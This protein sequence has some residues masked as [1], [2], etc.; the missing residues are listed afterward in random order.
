MTA[1]LAAPYPPDDEKP[2]SLPAMLPLLMMLPEPWRR[3]WGAACFMPSMT[4]RNRVAIAASKRATSRPSMPPVCA[5]PPALLNRQS[6]RPNFSTACAISPRISSSTV[7][8]VWRKRQLAPS[9]PASAS[10]SGARRPAM[11]IFAP[12][13]TNISA[14]RSPIP[15]VAPVMTATLPSSRP[16]SFSRSCDAGFSISEQRKLCWLS[17]EGVPSPKFALRAQTAYFPLCSALFWIRGS[18]D[19]THDEIDRRI[20][21]GLARDISTVTAF[22]HW[23]CSILRRF[24]DRGAVVSLP[25]PAGRILHPVFPGGILRSRVRRFQDWGRGCP[26]RGRTR[27]D[28]RFQQRVARFCEAGAS[29]DLSDGVRRHDMGHRALSIARLAS[30]GNF[31]TPDPGRGAAEAR[32]RR[33][34]A[35]AEKQI[36]DNSRRSP[37]GSAGSTANLGQHRSSDAGAVGD[38][39]SD[40]TGRRQR[41]RYQ[42]SL[43]L[44]TRTLRACSFYPE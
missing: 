24:G 16:I 6:R 37:S 32:C 25:D 43:A 1:A 13:A 23:I 34:S 27:R 8:S 4:L 26:R 42:G 15:L 10:P 22:E 12:S 11:T 35:P 5:G 21:A 28:R 44:R 38:R 17:T 14:V 7:T 30:T 2:A 3:I 18:V 36:V 9:L 40:R 19:V 31:K 20:S 29:G 39:R 41:L 33:A